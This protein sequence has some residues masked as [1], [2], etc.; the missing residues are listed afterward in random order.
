MGEFGALG[1]GAQQQQF[2]AQRPVLGGTDAS[3]VRGGAKSWVRS[4][5]A[6]GA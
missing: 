1:A 5:V 6:H 2:L 4:G 3:L